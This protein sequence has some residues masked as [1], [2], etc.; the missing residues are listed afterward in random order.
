MKHHDSVD[1]PLRTFLTAHSSVGR[2]HSRVPMEIV[3]WRRL[4]RGMTTAE[5]TEIFG[6]PVQ[7]HKKSDIESWQYEAG[8]SAMNLTLQFRNGL[9][10]DWSEPEPALYLHMPSRDILQTA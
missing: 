8:Q 10:F 6:T 2:H 3:Q 9:L 1:S 5:V 7:R 4:R